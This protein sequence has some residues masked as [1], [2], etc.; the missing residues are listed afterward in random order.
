MTLIKCRSGASLV[1][2]LKRGK[3]WRRRKLHLSYLSDDSYLP[4]VSR[5]VERD[6][7]VNS[8]WWKVGG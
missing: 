5:R 8:T 2:L 4:Y 7:R 6:T 3:D 1:L